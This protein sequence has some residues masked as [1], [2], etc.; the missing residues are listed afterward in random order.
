MKFEEGFGIELQRIESICLL[1]DLLQLSN[2][3]LKAE[4]T[5]KRRLSFSS[6]DRGRYQPER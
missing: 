1:P 6:T 4:T 3:A 2:A 5:S